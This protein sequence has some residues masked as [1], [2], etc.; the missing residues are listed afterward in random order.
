M[1]H[2]SR[3][4][5]LNKHKPRNLRNPLLDLPHEL[6]LSITDHLE[7]DSKVLLALSCKRLF[8]LLTTHCGLSFGTD[9]ALRTNFLRYL[10][11]DHPEFLTC[12]VCGW[13]FLW[14]KQRGISYQ[15]PRTM[16]HPRELRDSA[17]SVVVCPWS[18]VYMKQEL[19]DLVL[20]AHRRGPQHGLPISF[21]SSNAPVHPEFTLKTLHPTVGNLRMGTQARIVDGELMLLSFWVMELN[22]ADHVRLEM[23]AFNTALC[24]HRREHVTMVWWQQVAEMLMWKDTAEY[25][26]T[27]QCPFCASDYKLH[28]KKLGQGRLSVDLRVWR[29]FGNGCSDTED[30]KQIFLNDLHVKHLDGGIR[31]GRDLEAKFVTHEGVAQFAESCQHGTQIDCQAF[32]EI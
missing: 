17:A 2:L 29:N 5:S 22:S 23:R 26:V 7:Q 18:F 6:I 32:D 19:L 25:F 4:Q 1:S 28:V 12:R 11:I 10:G 13:M 20:R 21:L 3:P 31:S 30:V 24:W 16:R 8:V 15:C 27:H 14:R 9:V